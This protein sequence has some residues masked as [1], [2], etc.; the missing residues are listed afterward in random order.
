MEQVLINGGNIVS[1]PAPAGAAAR[2]VGAA[3]AVT[4]T[5]MEA[6]SEILQI[7][8]TPPAGNCTITIPQNPT[9]P[10][11]VGTPLLFSGNPLLL[12]GW[13]KVVQNNTTGANGLVFSAGGT[14]VTMAAA[15]QGKSQI[16]MSPDGVNIYFAGS[17]N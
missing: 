8:G 13:I 14:T 11:V 2:N 4:L 12:N 17:A 10:Q 6:A 15:T 9:G 1:A 3:A 7:T 5:S 16:L